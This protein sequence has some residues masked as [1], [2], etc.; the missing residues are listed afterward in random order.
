MPTKLPA[1]AE[2]WQLYTHSDRE[3]ISNRVALQTVVKELNDS[4]RAAAADPTLRAAIK[5][6]KKVRYW[7]ISE[8]EKSPEWKAVSRAQYAAFRSHIEPALNKYADYGAADTEPHY[9]ARKTLN[10]MV[11]DSMGITDDFDRRWL[12]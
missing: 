12:S 2:A 6:A 10:G 1:T 5:G 4:V 9:V 8:F 11:L 3:Q 7:S